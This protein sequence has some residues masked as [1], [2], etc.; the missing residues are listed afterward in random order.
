MALV[1]VKIVLDATTKARAMLRKKWSVQKKADSV[2][3]TTK[4]KIPDCQFYERN[5]SVLYG[6]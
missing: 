4:A 3:F 6:S 5:E 1:L 2:A